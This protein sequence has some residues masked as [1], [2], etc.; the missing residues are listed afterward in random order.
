ML[1]LSWEWTTALVLL[2][3]TAVY[4]SRSWLLSL[5][6]PKGIPG[7]PAF[8]YST[9]ILGDIPK[10]AAK[11][12]EYEKFS[13]FFDEVGRQLGPVAQVRLTAYKT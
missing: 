5:I 7:V 2:I 6:T 4:A 8:P 9:P 13:S 1:D 3:G 12:K 11:M 10:L